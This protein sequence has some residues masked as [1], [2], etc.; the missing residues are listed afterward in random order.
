[1]GV[2]VVDLVDNEAKAGGTVGECRAKDGDAL[3]ITGQDDGVFVLAILGEVSA[4]FL[5]EFA[6]GIGLGGQTVGNQAAGVITDAEFVFIDV[7]VVDAVN[8]QIA[9]GGVIHELAAYVV[10]EAHG[11]EEILV[12]DVG[13]GGD[14]GVDHVVFDHFDNDFFEAG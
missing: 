8:V 6:R 13:A 2:R 4:H 5:D 12:D 11:F 1:M 9:E 7:G 14:D 3:F 10:V